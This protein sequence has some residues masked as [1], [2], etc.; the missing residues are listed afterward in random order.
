MLSSGVSSDVEVR[1]TS[2]VRVL[3]GVSTGVTV[4]INCIVKCADERGI[5]LSNVKLSVSIV[6]TLV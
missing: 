2:D 4:C 6:Y 5:K 3:V 1:D